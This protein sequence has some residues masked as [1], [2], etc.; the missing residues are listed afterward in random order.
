M[1]KKFY[2]LHDQ[3]N[4]LAP[5]REGFFRV[6]STL[7]TAVVVKIDGKQES[8]SRNREVVALVVDELT[9]KKVLQD[10]EYEAQH[11]RA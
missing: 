5:V 8:L 3:K 6:L 7:N 1:W 4:K 9:R 2:G 10:E 11:K